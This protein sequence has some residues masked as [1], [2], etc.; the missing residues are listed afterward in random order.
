MEMERSAFDTFEQNLCR[1]LIIGHILEEEALKEEWPEI[2]KGHFKR[3]QVLAEFLDKKFSSLLTGEDLIEYAG[4]MKSCVSQLDVLKRNVE[5]ID[6]EGEIEDEE[7]I[8]AMAF[9]YGE[10]KGLE[11]TLQHMAPESIQGEKEAGN[12]SE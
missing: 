12:D 4:R 9:L 10:L 7:C 3:I 5:M 8:A 2:V 6:M 11:A 1:T